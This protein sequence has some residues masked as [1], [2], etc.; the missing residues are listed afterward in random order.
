MNPNYVVGLVDGEG[1]FS[2]Y[3]RKSGQT[4]TK[5]RVLVEPKFFVKL[6]EKDKV[7]LE[8]LRKFFDCGKIY[9]Q[10]DSRPNHQPCYRF[11][12]FNRNDLNEKIIPFFQKYPP[13]FPSKKKDFDLFREITEKINRGS[14]LTK[15]G[16][17]KIY[18]IKEKMH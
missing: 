17:L 15:Q 10:K 9:F 11:E 3:V 16:I 8:A 14:H 13:Q 1:S 6:V 2:V 18:R 4:R 12:V 5:R 7:I